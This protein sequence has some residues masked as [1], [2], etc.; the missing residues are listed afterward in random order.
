MLPNTMF[1]S[2]SSP[3]ERR[4]RHFAHLFTDFNRGQKCKITLRCLTAVAVAV[5]GVTRVGDTR[6]GNWG[7]HPPIFSWKT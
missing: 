1:V 4:I 7:C 6:G 5:G 2:E 3:L